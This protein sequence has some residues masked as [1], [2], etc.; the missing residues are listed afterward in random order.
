MIEI[1]I[2]RNIIITIAWTFSIV[3]RIVVMV[4]TL[5]IINTISTVPWFLPF[6]GIAYGIYPAL[7]KIDEMYNLR[8]IKEFNNNILNKHKGA[9]K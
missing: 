7:E 8:E 2:L 1:G 4:V 6:C 3:F 5:Y 9:E